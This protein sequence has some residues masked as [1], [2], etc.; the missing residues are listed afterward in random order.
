MKSQT[1]SR[2]DGERLPRAAQRRLARRSA[3]AILPLL[4]CAA[5]AQEAVEDACPLGKTV[6][7]QAEVGGDLSGQALE[8]ESANAFAGLDLEDL[9]QVQV[10]SVTG[11]SVSWFETPAAVTVLTAEDMRRAGHRSIA[12][13]LRLVPGM[14]VAQIS[15][16]MWAISV[17]GF[18]TRFANKLQVLMDGRRVYDPLY[19]GVFWDSLDTVMEDIDQIEVIRGPGA[20]LWGANAVN[21][22]INIKTKSAADTQGLLITGGGGNVERGFGAVRYGGKIDD[23][24]Y[25]R[26]YA[27]YRNFNSMP[28]VGAGRREDDWGMWQ[29][30]FRFDFGDPE[31]TQLTLQG[32]LFGIPGRDSRILSPSPTGHLESE[33]TISD[34]AFSGANLLTR[35]THRVD[36]SSHWALQA[37]YDNFN[38]DSF[39]TFKY[40]R[41][42]VDID[43]RHGFALGERN[44]VVWGMSFR[45]DRLDTTGSTLFSLVPSERDENTFSGFIQDTLTIV[46]DRLYGMLGTKVEHN[47]FSGFEVQPSVRMWWTPDE[48]QTVWAAFSMPVRTPSWIEKDMRFL[49]AYVDPG[50]LGPPMIPTHMYVPL[51]VSGTGAIE[52][53]RVR[54]WEAG[55]R[56]RLSDALTIDIS[57]FYSEYR[58]LAEIDYTL[59]TFTNN[60][61]AETR[62]VEIT[63]TWRIA[64]NWTIAGK[65]S[66]L[67]LD[68][69]TPAASDGDENQYPE[70]QF[71]LQSRV[72]LS[73]SLELNGSLY[74]VDE[75]PSTDTDSYTRLDIGL[76]WRPRPNVELSIWG[77]NLLEPRHVEI[78]Q[79]VV[80]LDSPAAIERSV[81]VQATFRF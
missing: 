36:D 24:A 66:Y 5:L 48:K 49:T 9:L 35:L 72:D 15:S 59:L 60:G 68:A 45:H 41:D 31:A 30:G 39:D 79:G 57:G 63:S 73:E 8:G 62:G 19:S 78:I 53:E 58:D 20:T 34:E 80:P 14:H 64:E 77:Q 42:S 71:Q 29:S 47:G 32:D 3:A 28:S 1:D 22:V 2:H 50:L 18:T 56:R 13:A 25:Y 76:T 75:L 16:G 43:F 23:D 52:S 46:P 51:Y 74:F 26:V 21:G 44:E 11:T 10:S 54:T 55:Y 17:R 37:Y 7:E 38:G 6:N 40:S 12:E 81:V 27:K 33:T 69:H 4:S 61:E 70:H 67:Q 65:Y